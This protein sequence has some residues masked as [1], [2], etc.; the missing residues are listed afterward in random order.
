MTPFV[1]VTANSNSARRLFISRFVIYADDAQM[2][3]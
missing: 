1:S 3:I 2:V